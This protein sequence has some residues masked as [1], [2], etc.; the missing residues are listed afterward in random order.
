MPSSPEAV[1]QLPGTARGRHHHPL[2]RPHPV[3]AVALIA[4]D[5][6]RAALLRHRFMPDISE[7]SLEASV[8]PGGPAG[9]DAPV[10]SGIVSEMAEP[11]RRRHH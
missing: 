7:M 9:N 1:N 5:A 2:Q 4:P 11:P 10:G 8:I 3:I 6:K